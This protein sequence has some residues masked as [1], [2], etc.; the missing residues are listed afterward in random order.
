MF[1]ADAGDPALNTWLLWWSTRR[2]PLTAAWWNAPMFYPMA[3]AMALSELLIGLLPITAPVQWLTGNPLLAYNAVFLSSFALS[4]LAAYG[5]AKELTH[6]RD[7]AVLAGLV[8]AFGPYRMNQ[9]SHIQMLAY[10]WAP[11]C[12]L[13]LH[14]FVWGRD[15]AA[16]NSQN[17]EAL[18]DHEDHE[19]EIPTEWLRDLRVFAVNSRRPIVSQ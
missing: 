1:P 8:F 2:V 17:H 15:V 19:T 14:R 5:L 9:L 11:I 7:A 13:A 18:E 16:S 3:D 4:G 12:L 6:R 10:Y